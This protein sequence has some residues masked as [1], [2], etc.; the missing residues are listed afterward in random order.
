[1]VVVS[2]GGVMRV[3][4]RDRFGSDVLPGAVRAPNTSIT[5]IHWD[6]LGRLRLMELASTEHLAPPGIST[7]E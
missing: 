3:F 7:V 1:M 4:L 2:H 5:R 6:N